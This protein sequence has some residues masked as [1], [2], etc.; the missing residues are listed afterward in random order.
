MEKYPGQ[1]LSRHAQ[2][3]QHGLELLSELLQQL[4]HFIFLSVFSCS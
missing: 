3:L 2:G 1:A 4:L